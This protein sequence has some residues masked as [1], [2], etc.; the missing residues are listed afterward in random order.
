MDE[1]YLTGIAHEAERGRLSKDL[2]LTTFRLCTLIPN[3]FLVGLDTIQEFNGVRRRHRRRRTL[4]IVAH[5]IYVQPLHSPSSQ[6]PMCIRGSGCIDAGQL[7]QGYVAR[8]L[9]DGATL[10]M[11]MQSKHYYD[12]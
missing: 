12:I 6:T 3:V 9:E 11:G 2:I 10:R 5:L 8:T 1:T 7:S 4:S